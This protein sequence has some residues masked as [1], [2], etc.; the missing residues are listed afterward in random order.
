MSEDFKNYLY[1]NL[2]NKKS[3]IPARNRNGQLLNLYGISIL[4]KD[5]NDSM[6]VVEI[7]NGDAFSADEIKSRMERNSGVVDKLNKPFINVFTQVFLFSG[8]IPQDKLE[9]IKSHQKINSWDKKYYVSYTIRLD[10]GQV[11]RHFQLP[12]DV[13]G[14]DVFLSQMI[15]TYT[16][17]TYQND[18][19]SRSGGF[20]IVPDRTEK[21]P[22]ITYILIAINILVWLGAILYQKST[23]LNDNEVLLKFGAKFNPLIMDGEYWRLITPAF[24]HLSLIHLLVNMFS[25]FIIGPQIEM[26]FGKVKCVLIYIIAG[27]FGNLASFIFSQN[28]SAGAS[29]AV[30]GFMG[31]LVYIWQKNRNSLDKSYILWVAGTIAYNIFYGFSKSG[32]DN[33]AHIGGLIG[34]YI[35][36]VMV[37]FAA[38]K[39]NITS[40]TVAAAL[41]ALLAISGL[42]AGFTSSSNLEAKKQ[43]IIGDKV[44]AL[45]NEASKSFTNN[46]FR[47]AEQLSKEALNLYGEN[48][49]VKA[50]A[51]RILTA[52]LINQ[53]KNQEAL[54][55]AKE[56]AQIS[57]DI[58]HYYLGLCY[59]N[60]GNYDDA[61]SELEKALK[62]DPSNKQ[63]Q[64]I[65][66]ELR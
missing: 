65:L 59:Y 20:R 34:G 24:L 1:T 6:F 35:A 43:Y 18:D 45:I 37:G 8:E 33:Y 56:L 7:F 54:T 10:L 44:E 39:K 13:D 49:D 29:G 15:D 42:Y 62:M 23:G 53:R 66:N 32:I 19:A 64:E 60:L 61:K 3:Y 40:R 41:I 27:F 30:F 28:P 22:V 11:Q 47:T 21:T 14:L 26:F 52:A 63:V 55:Y 25:L 31:V 4:D 48:K 50:V 58:G 5:S 46:D 12:P 9:I 57:P 2:I 51:T 38:R 36:A 17:H 16:M